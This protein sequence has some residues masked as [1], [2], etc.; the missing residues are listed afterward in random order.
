MT[1]V[2]PFRLAMIL[3]NY[4]VR[5]AKNSNPSLTTTMTFR[6]RLLPWKKFGPLSRTN[7]VRMTR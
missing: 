3:W 2:G 4:S 1:P 6:K 5:A 7:R